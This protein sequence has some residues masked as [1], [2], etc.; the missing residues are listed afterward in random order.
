VLSRIIHQRRTDPRIGEAL[1]AL[2]QA[3]LAQA[4]HS[5]EG[6]IVHRLQHDYTR[7]CRLPAELVAALAEA[8]SR[9]QQ[10]WELARAA[11][12]FGQF[13]PSLDEIVSL[14]RQAAHYLAAGGDPYDALLD[15][16]EE[17]CQHAVLAQQFEGL[18]VELVALATAIRESPRQPSQAIL[19][20]HYPRA[21]QEKFARH[22]TTAIGFDYQAGRLDVT[23]HPFCTT[24]GPR[25]CRLLTRYD[26]SCFATGL[27]GALHEAG[28]GLYE[29]GLEHEWYGLPPGTMVSL[30]IHE[31][32]SRLWE[33][34]VGRSRAFWQYFIGD[35]RS[36]FPGALGD[37]SVDDIHAAVNVVRP[38][39]IRVEA[40]EVTY[41]LH[42]II[43]FMLEQGLISGE[44]TT[45]D[46]PDA[47]NAAYRENLG[48]VPQNDGEGVLQ[49]VHW[50][51]G[52]FGY[53]PTYALGN[54]VSAQLL[55]AARHELGDLEGA[56][57]SGEFQ[58]LL[59]WLRRNVHRLGRRYPPLTLIERATG[60]SL[61][62]VPLVDGLWQ[63]Y[64]ELYELRRTTG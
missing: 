38:S 41:N 25:D 6:C 35:A 46:L 62:A 16:Y 7:D 5:T 60:S 14:K 17:G 22:C 43:R 32:Q 63:K 34:A 48:I 53:F 24:L 13:R 18:R 37:V 55:A 4:P 30:G 56:W 21:A 27:Y 64:A 47:W 12:D 28:H 29:Q 26:E 39:L 10:R 45:V 36:Q 50:S 20:R 11:R 51:A 61:S 44:I 23:A 40:D 8:T 57:R 31:S 9:G 33:N 2:V 3:D 59:D 54:L 49:D 58:P 15:L 19:H 42:I 1:A 52:L